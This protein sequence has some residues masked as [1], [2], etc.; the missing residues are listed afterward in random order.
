MSSFR[1]ERVCS[2][3]HEVA[4]EIIRDLKDPRL[5][6]VTITIVKVSPDIRHAKIYVSIMGDE[7]KKKETMTVLQNARGFIR[8]ETGKRIRLRYIPEIQF[9]NDESIEI[10]SHVLD[11]I[12]KVTRGDERQQESES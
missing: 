12:N 5:G 7:E 9:V 11:I 2:L 1:L 4:S 8:K 10:G 6:F 3:L